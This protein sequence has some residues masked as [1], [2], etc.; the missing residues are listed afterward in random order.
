MCLKLFFC[1]IMVCWIFLIKIHSNPVWKYN[2]LKHMSMR[3][4]ALPMSLLTFRSLIIDGN[5]H[6]PIFHLKS[7]KGT[8]W[9]LFFLKVLQQSDIWLPYGAPIVTTV[10]LPFEKLLPQKRT[11]KIFELLQQALSV[12]RSCAIECFCDYWGKL[13]N[14]SKHQKTETICQSNRLDDTMIVEIILFSF[15]SASLNGFRLEFKLS[16]FSVMPIL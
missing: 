15:A 13:A 3:S 7:I 6:I 12:F 5:E 1:L 8:E 9:R 14:I 4:L 16:Q 2:I 11:F 10:N